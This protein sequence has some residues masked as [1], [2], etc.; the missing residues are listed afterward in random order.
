MGVLLLMG[1][2]DIMEGGGTVFIDEGMHYN[3]SSL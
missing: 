1:D 2:P 3:A